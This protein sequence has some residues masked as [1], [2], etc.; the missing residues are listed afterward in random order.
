MESSYSSLTLT[1]DYEVGAPLRPLYSLRLGL[2]TLLYTLTPGLGLGSI[3]L[4]LCGWNRNCPPPMVQ[5]Y[6]WTP[7]QATYGVT[8]TP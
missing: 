4:W 8:P 2:G 5:A 6:F 1:F 7:Y 3:H